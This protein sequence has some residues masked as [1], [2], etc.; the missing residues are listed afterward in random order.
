MGKRVAM[1][2]NDAAAEAMRQIDPDVVAAYPITPQTE[3]MHKFAE[4]VADGKVSTEFVLVESEH[5]AMSA[6]VGASTAGARAMTATSSQGL[7]L[8]F[9][10]L[11]IASGL[12]LP[13]VMPMVNRALS[14]PL[15]IHCDHSDSMSCR[16][17][18]WLQLYAENTQ[19]VYDNI[20]MAVRIAEHPEVLLPVMICYDGFIISHTMEAV[21][22]LDDETAKRFVGEYQPKL[23]LLDVERPVTVGAL[24]LPDHYFEAKVQ[25]ARAHQ[26]AFTV[27][28]EI[29]QEFTK[30][31]GR[32]YDY[33]ESYR[34]EDKEVV[35]RLRSA[36]ERVGL[37]K[38]RVFRPFPHH[39]L[40]K[41]LGRTRAVAVLDRS[42]AFGSIGGPVY[43]EVRSALLDQRERV[44]VLNYV[45]GLGGRDIFCE[46]IGSV[47]EDLRRVIEM[48]STETETIYLGVRQEKLEQP[49]HIEV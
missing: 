24:Y 8:M 25:Q 6:T 32:S 28:Q 16:D 2:G 22:I 37:I 43:L 39:E 20:L 7:A 47:Y 15:N 23:Q 18:G 11:H 3:L 36:G 21:E 30:L 34:M 33:F 35:D 1:T 9:E 4:Y 41:A 45:Y 48:G 10:I 44:L 27:I 14:A 49:V 42:I 31:C 17:T 13:I 12:R 38:L 40:A 26:T 5:S 19:E 46:D 29:A